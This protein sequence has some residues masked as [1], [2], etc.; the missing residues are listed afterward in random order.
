[1][2]PVMT[3]IITNGSGEAVHLGQSFMGLSSGRCWRPS[4]TTLW[5]TDEG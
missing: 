2:T 1:M 4:F 3:A 5:I